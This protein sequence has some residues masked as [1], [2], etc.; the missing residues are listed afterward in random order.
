MLPRSDVPQELFF[1]GRPG[2]LRLGEWVRPVTQL[3][4]K[5]QLMREA[6]LLGYPDDQGVLANRGRAGAALGPASIRKHLYRMTLPADGSW[7]KDFGLLDL[8]DIQT[9]KALIQ[10]HDNART[11]AAAAAAGDRA[12]V[13]LG[14]GHDFAWPTFEGVRSLTPKQRWGLINLDPH[15][16][17]RE[18]EGAEV[19]SGNPFRKL[20]ETGALEGSRFV[21]FGARPNRNTA[22]AWA[23]CRQQKVQILP[24]ETL[25]IGKKPVIEQFR[26][27][28]KSL[29]KRCDA[30]GITLDMDC[31]SEAEG[32]SAAPVLGFSAWEL[33]AFARASGQESQ[34]KYLE[35]AETAPGLDPTERSSRIAAEVIFAFLTGVAERSFS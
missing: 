8:G 33:C 16:D 4:P 25:R 14:G 35:I 6:V 29:L 22:S 10:T 15:L 31:C 5:R 1:K 26:I 30:I 34:V 24:L 27:T 18:M 23:Y 21:Q 9:A 32:T 12:V 28:L 20:L 19:H 13:A 7:K 2:D 11:L 17:A 3:P